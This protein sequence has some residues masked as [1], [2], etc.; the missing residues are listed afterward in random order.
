MAGF[1]VVLIILIMAGALVVSSHNQ[2]EALVRVSQQA[3][4]SPSPLRLVVLP[5][6]CQGK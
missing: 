1:F 5:V 4:E 2:A 6:T 3:L